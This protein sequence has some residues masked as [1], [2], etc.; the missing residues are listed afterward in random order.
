MK[1]RRDDKIRMRL[2]PAATKLARS[3]AAGRPVEQHHLD[4]AI[5]RLLKEL[6]QHKRA[7]DLPANN[8]RAALASLQ[9]EVSTLRTLLMLSFYDAPLIRDEKLGEVLRAIEASRREAADMV[10]VKFEDIERSVR[11]TD[12]AP[13]LRAMGFS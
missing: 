4:I 8:L 12:F 6:D 7:T 11:T 5:N 9:V 2:G 10:G 1:I 13:F 3:E